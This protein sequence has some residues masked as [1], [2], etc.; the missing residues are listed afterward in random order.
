M[1]KRQT[2]QLR[3]LS[4]AGLRGVWAG[5]LLDKTS[6]RELVR[7]G[8]ADNGVRGSGS[9]NALTTIYITKIGKQA[10]HGWDIMQDARDLRKSTAK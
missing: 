8:W 6:T 3:Q 4:N 9:P 5:D 1:T 10:L 2:D 7:G